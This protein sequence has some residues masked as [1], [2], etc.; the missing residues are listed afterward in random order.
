MNR[1]EIVRQLKMLDPECECRKNKQDE[2]I[3]EAIDIISG[4]IPHCLPEGF[5]ITIGETIGNWRIV[6]A[7]YERK[8]ITLREVNNRDE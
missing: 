2:A 6:G 3:A 7:D 8:T 1:L 4:D 5:P